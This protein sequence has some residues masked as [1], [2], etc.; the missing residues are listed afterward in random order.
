MAT[1]LKGAVTKK[2]NKGAPSSFYTGEKTNPVIQALEQEIN[3]YVG[4]M[5]KRFTPGYKRPTEDA[6]S[7]P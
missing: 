1:M 5:K 2:I 7:R 4:Y 3:L 6:S